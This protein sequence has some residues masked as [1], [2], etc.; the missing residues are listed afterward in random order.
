MALNHY[1]NSLLF[2]TFYRLKGVPMRRR[3]LD[4]LANLVKASALKPAFNQLRYVCTTFQDQQVQ[5]WRRQRGIYVCQRVIAVWHANAVKQKIAK[6][7]FQRKYLN[8]LQ[9]HV[10]QNNYVRPLSLH[11]HHL[12][13]KAFSAFKRM[14]NLRWQE[15]RAQ[16]ILRALEQKRANQLLRGCYLAFMDNILQQKKKRIIMGTVMDFRKHTLAE[17]TFRYWKIYLMKQKKQNLMNQVAK[18]FYEEKIQRLIE[19]GRTQVRLNTQSG[20]LLNANQDLMLRVITEWKFATRWLKRTKYRLDQIVQ[21]K[22]QLTTLKCFLAW[23]AIA[24]YEQSDFTCSIQRQ[25][26]RNKPGSDLDMLHSYEMTPSL[27]NTYSI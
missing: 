22:K 20:V 19:K 5:E 24:R 27:A 1:K 12:K 7:F 23:R 2:R 3:G 9:E 10:L 13:V 15:D 14:K 6:M 4:V 8:A 16:L 17:K 25:Q 21:S 11:E 18:E 26:A